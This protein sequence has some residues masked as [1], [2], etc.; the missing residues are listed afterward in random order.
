MCLEKHH[1]KK[2]LRGCNGRE[3]DN[4]QINLNKVGCEDF[5]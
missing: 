2:H 4:S 5:G 1:K 3:E